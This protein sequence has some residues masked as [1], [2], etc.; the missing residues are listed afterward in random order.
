MDLFL[1]DRKKGWSASASLIRFV[2]VGTMVG[3]GWIPGRMER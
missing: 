1:N 3:L 2:D